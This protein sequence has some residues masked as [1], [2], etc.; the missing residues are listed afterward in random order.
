[1][2]RSKKGKNEMLRSSFGSIFFLIYLCISFYQ[3]TDFERW[4]VKRRQSDQFEKELA[5][6]KKEEKMIR[7]FR[8]SD[9]ITERRS[10]NERQKSL[11]SSQNRETSDSSNRFVYNQNSLVYKEHMVKD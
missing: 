2:F 5:E 11:R 6:R 3:L 10:S 8:K 9:L 1:M 7:K 4:L